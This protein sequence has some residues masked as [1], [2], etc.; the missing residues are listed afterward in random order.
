MTSIVAGN[1]AYGLKSVTATWLHESES[2]VPVVALLAERIVAYTSVKAKCVESSMRHTLA[3]CDS[4]LIK[5]RDSLPYWVSTIS[6][7][8][9]DSPAP[10][11]VRPD[12]PAS[13]RDLFPQWLSDGC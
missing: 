9:Y 1:P 4:H 2:E 6:G 11:Q 3:Q 7:T 8:V 5:R 12:Q 10:R 13:A